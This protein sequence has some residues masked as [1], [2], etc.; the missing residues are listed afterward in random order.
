MPRPPSNRTTEAPLLKYKTRRKN[1]Y[2]SLF[3]CC[4][5]FFMVLFILLLIAF[6]IVF[7]ILPLIFKY[8]VEL[9]KDLVF[10][11][12]DLHPTNAQFDN[13]S[14]YD[15]YG[16][17]NIYVSV[18]ESENIVL[19][20][21]HLLP[22]ALVNISRENKD[23]NYTESLTKSDYPIVLHFHGNGG[24]RV[25]N[26][27]MYN[28]LRMFFHVIAFDYRCYGDSSKG[29]LS[30]ANVVDD[31]VELYKWLTLQTNAEVYFWGHSLGSSI[32]AHTIAKLNKEM[33]APAGLFL[34]S[35]FNRL[36]DEVKY[37]ETLFW[38][39]KIF[40]WMPWYEA[41]MVDP[42]EE[43]GLVF[44]TADYILNVDCPI[45]I[46]HAEDDSVVPIDLGRRLYETAI[47]FRNIS[48]QG[49]VTF[50]SIPESLEL[51]HWHIYAVSD[52]PNYIR[53]HIDECEEFITS[54][55]LNE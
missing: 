29:V 14:N 37:V 50:Y 9:Q 20:V 22:E 44:N 42:F 48:V 36:R 28:V 18:N 31:S 10:P 41:T 27:E 3:R 26:L 4:V 19:G 30:E 38:F 32:S 43:N 33:I 7:V 49:N 17:R 24:N 54:N 55:K 23:F 53:N 47:I 6:I 16:A 21:W 25:A 34:E 51:N 1:K 13:F 52:L 40:L 11:I 12:Y 35:P 2:A 8:S 46:I 45:M 39:T 5:I 15:L